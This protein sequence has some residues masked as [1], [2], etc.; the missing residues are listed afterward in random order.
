MDSCGAQRCLLSGLSL[1]PRLSRNCV[2]EKEVSEH[3][4][5]LATWIR[6]RHEAFGFAL[7]DKRMQRGANTIS[8]RQIYQSSTRSGCS[9]VPG[10]ARTPPRS[11]RQ[12]LVDV[13][14]PA[15][16]S[17]SIGSGVSKVTYDAA[18]LLS[19]WSLLS[20]SPPVSGT[21]MW[22]LRPR[23]DNGS[24]LCCSGHDPLNGTSEQTHCGNGLR[25]R[26]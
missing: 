12:M 25:K 16:E 14:P 22:M 18:A 26:D 8:S 1:V 5:L 13:A 17:P 10:E 3:T 19:K 24:C 6:A 7:L 9:G 2:Q 11:N 20:P 15:Q 4:T 23:K 21:C